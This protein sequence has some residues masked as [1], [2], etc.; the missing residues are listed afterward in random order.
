DPR[1][2]DLIPGFH[3]AISPNAPLGRPGS[4][5]FPVNRDE[6]RSEEPLATIESLRGKEVIGGPSPTRSSRTAPA[7]MLAANHRLASNQCQRGTARS[8]ASRNRFSSLS[9]G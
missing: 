5:R 7:S 2:R 9:F 6:Q 1:Q 4:P 3:H 8:I